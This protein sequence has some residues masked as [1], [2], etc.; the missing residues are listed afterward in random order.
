MNKSENQ[1]IATRYA[2]SL[3]ELNEQNKLD[4]SVVWQNLE[5]IKIIL[6]SS[7]ELYEALVNPIISAGDKE[8]VINSIFEKDTDETMRNFLKL[9][10]RKNRFNLIF[11]VVKIY[12]SLLDKLN[13]ISKVEVISAIELNDEYKNQIK[14]KLAQVLNKEII[15]SYDVN[16]SILAG[17]VYKMGDDVFD[18]SLAGK[19]DRFKNAIIK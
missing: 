8:A 14:E 18:T 12:N 13:N 7:K 2:K 19:I 3:F 5:N 4:N 11:D 6:E 15:V 1:L 17:L 9:L 16:N 10:V